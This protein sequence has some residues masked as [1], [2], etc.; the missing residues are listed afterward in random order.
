VHIHF[1]IRA[2]AANGQVADFT[3]QVFFP[4]ELN[5]Q[6]LAQAP[7]SQKNASGRLRNERDGIFQGS[8]GKLTL[9]PAKNA[10][11]YAAT[12]DIGLVA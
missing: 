11:G 5:D 10:D 1:K 12:F 7:Y 3:S 8:G 9:A 4:E 6:V 2:T